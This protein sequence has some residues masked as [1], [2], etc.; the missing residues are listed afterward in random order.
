MFT[1]II[2]DVGTIRQVRF[3]SCS[4]SILVSAPSL[5]TD[6]KDGDSIAVNGV[7]LTVCS[8]SPSTFSADIMHE[9]L[10]RST[11]GK[12]HAGNKVNLERAMRQ[13]GRF[14]GHIVT[15]HIDGTGMIVSRTADGIARIYTISA[16]SCILDGIVM[17]GS[18]AVDGISLTI[19]HL[20]P[21]SF[22]VSVIPRTAGHTSLSMKK[23]G[24]NV[25]IETD[26]IGKYISSFMHKG[27]P[28]CSIQ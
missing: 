9:T 24:D 17:K 5:C 3:T 1:G 13:D 7:C 20:L 15:G 6:L 23:E 12:L 26:Y 19:M 27:A 10:E 8:H 28:S 21:G 14:G 25:N 2:E 16:G 18:I 11:L 4:G 22:S